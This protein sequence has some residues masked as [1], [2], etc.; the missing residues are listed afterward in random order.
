[1][2]KIIIFILA[3][4][5]NVYANE[6]ERILDQANKYTVKI[7]N[8]TDTPFIED[9]YSP[10]AGSGFLI[11]KTNGIIVTNAHVASYS[12]AL[13]RVN[14]KHSNPVQSKQIYIDTDI[15][16]ALLKIDPAS[17]PKE[18]VEAKLHCKNDYKQGQSVVAFGHPAGKDFTIT[19]GIISAVRFESD[20]FESIQTDAAINRGN[21]GGA[22]IDV[23]TGIVV[24]INSF[25]VEDNQGLNFALPSYTVCKVLDLF[26][27]KKDPSPLNFNVIFSNNKEQGKFLKVSEVLTADSSLKVGDEITQIDGVKVLNPTQLTHESRGK[28]NIIIKIIRDNK[29]QELK[30]N[31]KSKGSVTERVGLIFSNVI[32]SDKASST[33]LAINQRMANPKT[34]L[35]V[36]NLRSGPASGKLRKFDVLIYVDGKEFKTVQSLHDY[37]KD[38]KEIEVFFRRPSLDEERKVN[39]TDYHDKIEVKDVKMLRFE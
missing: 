28:T 10:S 4:T 15:D 9:S 5:S 17:I 37:L 25:G 27:N 16:L 11:D 8:S 21:S 22:L 7:Y 14:F 26:K 24:G 2:K 12:P 36:Q 38:K 35:V 1:M 33:R 29:E 20:F 3:L 32:V 30:I 18:A 13:N 39:F 19:R 34:N 31:L 6:L 23:S